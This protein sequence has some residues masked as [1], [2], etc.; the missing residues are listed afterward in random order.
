MHRPLRV[1][2]RLFVSLSFGLAWPAFA[3]TQSHVYVKNETRHALRIHGSEAGGA[4]VNAKAWQQGVGSVSPGGR[5][6]VLTLNRKGKVNWMDP[7]PRF[8]EPGKEVVFSTLVT[9][10]DA[11][12]RPVVLLQKLLGTGQTTTM[13]YSIGTESGERQWHIDESL[14]R[15]SWRTTQSERWTIDFRSYREAGETHVEYTIRQAE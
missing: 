6:I 9:R 15:A 5:A 3:Q 10:V 1:L 14:H 12:D 11:P 4:E 13:W 7:T 8:I 2:L